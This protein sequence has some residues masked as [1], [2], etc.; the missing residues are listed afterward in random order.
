MKILL[1]ESDS[2]LDDVYADFI[3]G[4]DH[5]VHFVSGAS[6]A[7]DQIQGW[8]PDV[9]IL[10][11]AVTS[12]ERSLLEH[13]VVRASGI[14]V[15]AVVAGAIERLGRECLRLGAVD[16]P[17]PEPGRRQDAA[18]GV[19][20]ARGDGV[21]ALRAA[22]RRRP[23]HLK[24]VFSRAETDGH[25]F[26]FVNLSD[27]EF[28]RLADYSRSATPPSVPVRPVRPLSAVGNR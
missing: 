14:P 16:L 27:A 11:M 15:I 8:P 13:P 4:L 10:D 21:V 22:R 19:D 28:K 9:V 1:A 24:A 18:A 17:R 23:L 6:A 25:I 3:R 7:L 20:R 5:D 12:T 26:T 2:R